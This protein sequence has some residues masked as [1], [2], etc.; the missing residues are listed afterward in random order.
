MDVNRLVFKRFLKIPS[1]A[2]RQ[3]FKVKLFQIS[4]VECLKA[5]EAAAGLKFVLVNKECCFDMVR[6][7]VTGSADKPASYSARFWKLADWS[8]LCYAMLHQESVHFL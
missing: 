8:C 1:E 5:R 6:K 4:G 2:A 7:E 3:L